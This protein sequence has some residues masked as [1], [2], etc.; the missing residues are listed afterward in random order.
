MFSI[1]KINP[2]ARAIVTVGAVATLAGGIT[3]ANLTSNTVA[4]SPNTLD[5]ANASLEIGLTNTGNCADAN[6]GPR[7]GLNFTGST[8]L[9]PG[10]TTAPFDFC[11]SNNGSLPLTVSAGIPQ[12]DF[13]SDTGIPPSDVTLNMTCGGT[14]GST[15]NGTLDQYTGGSVLYTSLAAGSETDCQATVTLAA[16]YSGQGNQAVPSFDIDFVGNQ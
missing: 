15:T 6:A 8:A 10:V 16:S 5:S 4:L 13:A 2:M 3:F 14:G 12:T 1:R 7:T 11:I 9:V